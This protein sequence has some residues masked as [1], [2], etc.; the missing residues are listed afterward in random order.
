MQDY[1]MQ[2]YAATPLADC[3]K[4]HVPRQVHC[5]AS[6]STTLSTPAF[7]PHLTLVGDIQPPSGACDVESSIC[8]AV[9]EAAADEGIFSFSLRLQ[10]EASPMVIRVPVA[11]IIHIPL[12]CTES[13]RCF[14]V[15]SSLD[16]KPPSPLEDS[17]LLSSTMSCKCQ[18]QGTN[19]WSMCV[20]QWAEAMGDEM[21]R[22]REAIVE[23]LVKNLGM[24][25]EARAF[26]PHMSLVYGEIP[27]QLRV[28]LA[29]R[30]S[31]DILH[32]VKS[33]E[34][35]LDVGSIMLIETPVP[36]GPAG[37]PLWREVAEIPLSKA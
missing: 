7:R 16:R 1:V 17:S 2:D 6:L 27:Y 11:S 24:Q 19:V 28:E 35:T 20:L 34:F 14:N 15:A 10:P 26:R 22:L 13:S 30:V 9:Q 12:P 18:D 37:I 21:K 36:A 3:V 31:A 4:L 29:A 25:V 32:K 5:I 23:K 33:H 8:S